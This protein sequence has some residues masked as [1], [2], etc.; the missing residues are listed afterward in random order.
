MFFALNNALMDVGVWVWGVKRRHDYVR[1][2]SAV[3][4]LYRGTPVSAWA[5]PG[6]GTQTIDGGAWHPYQAAT[7][8]TPPFAEYV[9][10]HS[11]FS[12]AA[13]ATLRLFTGSDRFGHG[14][15]LRAGSSRIEGGAVP[16]ADVTLSW[17]TFSQAAD[18]AGMSRRWGG[19]HF[20]DGDLEGRRVGGDIGRAA[21]RASMQLIEGLGPAR[22]GHARDGRDDDNG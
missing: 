8:V 4:W 17:A 14:V 1:P 7:F 6:L 10:G 3:R 12:A 20:R 2:I 9:S 18:E 15:T 5:G 11:T 19:I 21:W 13:A 16:A 22:R